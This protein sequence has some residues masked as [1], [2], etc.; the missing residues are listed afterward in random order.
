MKRSPMVN[1]AWVAPPRAVQV[2]NIKQVQSLNPSSIDSAEWSTLLA[3]VKAGDIQI[4]QLLL[5]TNPHLI[6]ERDHESDTVLHWAAYKGYEKLVL[7]LIAREPKLLN[8]V[9]KQGRTPYV[10]AI[11]KYHSKVAEILRLVEIE[12]NAKE[13]ISRVNENKTANKSDSEYKN[14]SYSPEKIHKILSVQLQNENN[15]NIELL[16]LSDPANLSILEKQLQNFVSLPIEENKNFAIALHL[17]GESWASLV[18]KHTGDENLQLIYNDPTGNAFN[19]EI[20]V[21]KLISSIIEQN[22]NGDT[23]VTDLRKIQQNIESDSGAMVIDNLIKIAKAPSS[24]KADLQKL[25][26]GADKVSELKIK[27]LL[28]NDTDPI[29]SVCK[30]EKLLELSLIHKPVIINRV[31]TF[32]DEALLSENIKNVIDQITDNGVPVI[33]PLIT[34]NKSWSG[35]VIKSRGDGSLQIIYS[36]PTGDLLKGEKNSIKLI[37]A[38]IEHNPEAHII[39]I[40]YKQDEDKQAS[41]AF[42]VNNLIKFALSDTNNFDMKDFQKILLASESIDQ[43][44]LQHD[45]L[46]HEYV[47]PT[48]I[49]GSAH[50]AFESR[51]DEPF[52]HKGDYLEGKEQKANPHEVSSPPAYEEDQPVDIHVLGGEEL[53]NLD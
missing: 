6:N 38:I 30:L 40:K 11:S 8:A 41:G 33:I 19:K 5:A 4:V 51:R 44:R 10:E 35:L 16:D 29:Y 15:V 52:E 39:D 53:H 27:H 22:Q 50:Y 24:K 28:I 20:A 12:F 9:N 3:A 26:L 48:L 34:Q 13:N 49:A 7:M 17:H 32:E 1:K 25:L 37:K 47:T 36:N 43:L 46:I 18:I 2:S 21:Q 42:I 31:I 23:L 14:P 45:H